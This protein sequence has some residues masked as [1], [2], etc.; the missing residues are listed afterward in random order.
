MRLLAVAILLLCVQPASAQPT[1]SP[2]PEALSNAYRCAEVQDN[3]ARLACYDEAVGRLREAE[4]AGQIV[5]LDREGVDGLQR[6]SFGFSLPNFARLIPGIGAGDN[7]GAALERIEMQVD[8]IINLPYGRHNFVMSN[9]QTWAQ[10][11][12]QATV[13]IRV[14]D[15]VTVRR[16]AMGS[17]LLSPARGGAAHRVHR[18]G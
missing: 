12:A 14:G 7:D 16:A 2:T 13:N 18:Q 8:R 4:T 3:A 5:A 10:T 6:D 15:T 1:P 9:G 17:F 11:E